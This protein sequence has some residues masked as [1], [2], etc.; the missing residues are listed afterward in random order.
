[1]RMCVRTDNGLMSFGR[2][3]NFRSRVSAPK[4]RSP[5]ISSAVSVVSNATERAVATPFTTSKSAYAHRKVTWRSL[6]SRNPERFGDIES[7]HFQQ[8]VS[9]ASLAHDGAQLAIGVGEDAGRGVSCCLPVSR[10]H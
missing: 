3:S 2:G 4:L 5:R 7:R 6:P 9:H 1:M 10:G 8:Q